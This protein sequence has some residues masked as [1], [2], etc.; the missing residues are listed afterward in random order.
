M[1]LSEIHHAFLFSF[2]FI[3]FL[4]D[5][6]IYK[7]S[8]DFSCNC[9]LIFLTVIF[10]SFTGY[11]IAPATKITVGIIAIGQLILIFK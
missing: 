3:Y 2:F 4:N 8:V 5:I 9:V 7:S 6:K 1:Q 11:D 10:V